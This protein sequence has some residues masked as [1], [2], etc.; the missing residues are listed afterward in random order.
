MN[1]MQTKGIIKRVAVLAS[2]SAMFVPFLFVYAQPGAGSSVTALENPIGKITSFDVLIKS[3]L[4]IVMTIGIPIAVLAIIYSGFL[5]VTA[6]GNPEKL[7]SAKNALLWTVVGTAILLGSWVLA[8][9]ISSTI[10][11]LRT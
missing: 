2:T 1:N 6:Q 3:I 9:A 8:T 5:F 7:E 4:N 11:A 10:G